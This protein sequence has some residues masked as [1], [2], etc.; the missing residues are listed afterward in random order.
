[1][2]KQLKVFSELVSKFKEDAS[3]YGVLLS[4]SLATGTATELSDLDIIVLSEKIGF[5]T[6]VIDSVTV[7]IHYTTFD[8]AISKIN[9]DPM[10]VYKYLDSKIEYDN[11]KLYE[12]IEYAKN[13]FDNYRI[14]EK[15]KKAI[16]HWLK[17]VKIKLQSAFSAKNTLLVAYLTQTNVWKVLEGIWAVNQKPVPPSM[18]LYRRYS[19]L[20]HIPCQNWLGSLLIGDVD[21]KGKTMI[22]LIDW[23][24]ER[25]GA[26]IT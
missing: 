8:N 14:S 15:D 2:L 22:F 5:E 9:S 10:E 13:A 1:M 11:G 3:V 12:I 16:A 23:I 19:D 6:T 25:L 7:E 4:G 17:S 20:E 18:S 26:P 21:T 24:I